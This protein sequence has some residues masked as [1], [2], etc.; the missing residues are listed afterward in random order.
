MEQQDLTLEQVIEQSFD[1]SDYSPEEKKSV[2][3]ETTGMIMETALLRTL[4]E[5]G[6]EAQ[7]KFASFV[8]TDPNEEQM[9][10][11][12]EQNFPKFGEMIVEEIK[13]F[14]EMG[15]QTAEMQTESAE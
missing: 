14:K 7:E 6:N 12:I 15:G 10:E 5:A 3:E 11:Y 2:L 4:D 13:I 8:E 9:S 1:F